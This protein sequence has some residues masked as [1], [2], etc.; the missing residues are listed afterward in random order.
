MLKNNGIYIVED[1]HCSYWKEYGGGIFDMYSSIAFFKS[2]IDNTSYDQWGIDAPPSI[3]SN[4]FFDF[5]KC[6][7]DEETLKEISSIY[8]T[9]SL[10][11]LKKDKHSNN[12]LGK[13][14]VNGVKAI[15]P[16]LKKINGKYNEVLAQ[17][18][19]KKKTISNAER[20]ISLTKQIEK[21]TQ[22]IMSLTEENKRMDDHLEF[23]TNEINLIK[24][25]RTWK[26]IQLLDAMKKKLLH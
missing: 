4:F 9:N 8:F 10:C 21:K 19:D 22:K 12:I 14:R 2:L 13:R 11:I 25:S 23:L 7:I 17:N 18:Y 1:L 26:L 3:T 20:V 24:S 5:Y 6:K 15:Y 16:N